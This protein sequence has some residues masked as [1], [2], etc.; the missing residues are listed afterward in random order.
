MS[1]QE[2]QQTVHFDIFYVPFYVLTCLKFF[3]STSRRKPG[4]ERFYFVHH[5]QKVSFS[6][7]LK[8]DTVTLRYLAMQQKRVAWHPAEQ[9]NLLS[10][11][12]LM[13][14]SVDSSIV[15]PNMALPGLVTLRKYSRGGGCVSVSAF[16][17][18]LIFPRLKPLPKLLAGCFLEYQKSGHISSYLVS[19]MMRLC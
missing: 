10:Y 19:E 14:S 2:S 6:V 3:F 13:L 11:G 15:V 12:E 18:V 4:Q 7:D 5:I 17:T 8:I 16:A 1:Q 9:L